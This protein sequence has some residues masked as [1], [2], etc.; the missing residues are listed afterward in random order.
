VEILLASTIGVFIALVAVGTLRA[1]S[2]SAEMVD[3]NIDTASQLRFA[4]QKI[5][6]DLV[7]L[8][9]DRNPQNT[10]FVGTIVPTES[11]TA[12]CL[13]LYTVGRVNARASQPEGDVYEVEYRLINSETGSILCRRLWPNPDKN[14]PPGGVLSV[15]AEDIGLFEV[16]YYDGQNWQDEWPEEMQSIPNLVAVTI[17]PGYEDP[18]NKL[19]ESFI[20]NFPRLMRQQSPPSETTGQF[21]TTELSNITELQEGERQ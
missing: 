9:R 1:I 5:T 10:R 16:R 3:N 15:I 12:S 20:V 18:R 14:E 7:N 21:E 8:Y 4:A 2:S 13:T 19:V 11:G 6:A 17:A